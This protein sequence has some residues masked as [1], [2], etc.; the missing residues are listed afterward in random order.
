MKRLFIAIAI[1]E[2][3]QK[4][5]KKIYGKVNVNF[6]SLENLHITLKF[7]GNVELNKEESIHLE[8]TQIAKDFSPF[9]IKLKTIN[10]FY[11][12]EKPVVLWVGIEDRARLVDLQSKINHVLF[13]NLKIPK[14]KKKFVPHLTLS[15]LKKYNEKLLLKFIEEH[16]DFETDSF[17]VDRFYLYSSVTEQKGAIYKIEREYEL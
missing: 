17:A 9:F 6:V 5:L 12:K 15:R 4:E 3:I 13:D 14:E 10:C 8:L 11:R 16:S 7:F 2:N 1:P